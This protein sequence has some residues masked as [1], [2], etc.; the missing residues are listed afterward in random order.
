MATKSSIPIDSSSPLPGIKLF[1]LVILGAIS[2]LIPIVYFL[3][4]NELKRKDLDKIAD[5]IKYQDTISMLQR[6][7]L[8]DSFSNDSNLLKAHIRADSAFFNFFRQ[9]QLAYMP[10][11][12]T[13]PAKSSLPQPTNINNFPNSSFPGSVSNPALKSSISDTTLNGIA[14][15]IDT[16]ESNARLLA[17][18]L[19]SLSSLIPIFQ[20]SILHADRNNSVQNVQSLTSRLRDLR[21]MRTRTARD[22]QFNLGLDTTSYLILKKI[23][24]LITFL[25]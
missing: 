1:K 25:K 14:Q 24:S 2:C 7:H 6:Q 10:R 11:Q 13:P 18:Q 16:L 22:Q 9:Q 23:D 3:Q 12:V 21:Q 19:K 4:A 15:R 20:D 8:I 17:N 5:K